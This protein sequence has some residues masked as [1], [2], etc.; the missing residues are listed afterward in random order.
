MVSDTGEEEMTDFEYEREEI[1]QGAMRKLIE[2][3][4]EEYDE[5]TGRFREER[6]Q[7]LED[8]V[9]LLQRTAQ[10]LRSLNPNGV[11]VPALTQTAQALVDEND[12]LHVLLKHKEQVIAHLEEKLEAFTTAVVSDT[13]EGEMADHELAPTRRRWHRDS[14]D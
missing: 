3:H 6:I 11:Q 2:K 5:L 10:E 12:K 14:T 4:R 13:G 7:Q 8:R 1:H 9:A